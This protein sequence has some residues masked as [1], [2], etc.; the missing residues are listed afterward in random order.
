MIWLLTVCFIV[1][2]I[3]LA[4]EYQEGEW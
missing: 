2:A 1:V 3:L 4:S